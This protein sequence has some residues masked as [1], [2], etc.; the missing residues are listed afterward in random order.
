MTEVHHYQL[1]LLCCAI[2]WLLVSPCFSF[3]SLQEA[4]QLYLLLSSNLPLTV[5]FPYLSSPNC[6]RST[7]NHTYEEVYI[8]KTQCSTW[9]SHVKR[10]VLMHGIH[11]ASPTF[12]ILSCQ[13][14]DSRL[15][16]LEKRSYQMQVWPCRGVN[17]PYILLYFKDL[18]S[19]FFPT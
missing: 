5:L 18:E 6:C 7:S 8:K 10:M 17:V 4:C 1:Q 9:P 11:T 13:P 16:I 3:S 2:I 15:T 12:T 14:R 19:G